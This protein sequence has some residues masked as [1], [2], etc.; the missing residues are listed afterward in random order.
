MSTCGCPGAGPQAPPG[1]SPRRALSLQPGPQ[2]AADRAV[3]CLLPN[4]TAQPFGFGRR[5]ARCSSPGD[6]WQPWPRAH[7]RED[8]RCPCSRRNSAEYPRPRARISNDLPGCRAGSTG[9]WSGMHDGPRRVW[10]GGDEVGTGCG[11]RGQLREW[12]ARMAALDRSGIS[13]SAASRACKMTGTRESLAQKGV[14]GSGL[15]RSDAVSS[16][17]QVKRNRQVRRSGCRRIR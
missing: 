5:S 13:R 2:R 17:G 11:R 10:G 1:C 9:C 15:C 3:L 7:V 8:A 4:L 6:E 14:E 12:A 16:A